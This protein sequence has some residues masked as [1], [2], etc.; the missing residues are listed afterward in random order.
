MPP[1]RLFA[2]MQR[3]R[4]RAGLVR[5][6]VFRSRSGIS[7]SCPRSRG[8]AF[9]VV[10]ARDSRAQG[11]GRQQMSA[12][13]GSL[14][15][16][17]YVATREGTLWLQNVQ[18]ALYTRSKEHLG[19]VFRE[20]L[21]SG[22]RPPEPPNRLRPRAAESRRA[23]GGHIPENAPLIARRRGAARKLRDRPAR[24][25]EHGADPGG[26]AAIHPELAPETHQDDGDEK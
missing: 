11:E 5:I 20:A 4:W 2:S 22:D 23:D 24:P 8:G 18:H 9:V 17:M 1:A 25:A 6:H 15:Q 21:G 13:L 3:R 26:A 12:A 16:A 19:Y 7:R 10:R 14:G